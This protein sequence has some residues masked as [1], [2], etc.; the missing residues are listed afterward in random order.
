MK[1][2]KAIWLKKNFDASKDRDDRT[3]R[4]IREERRV[5]KR[6]MS[7]LER[8]SGKKH[9]ILQHYSRPS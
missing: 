1:S 7:K 9:E 6:Q 5:W 2:R 3:A 4:Q 8:K